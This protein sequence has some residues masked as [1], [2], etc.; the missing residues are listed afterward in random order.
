MCGPNP[1]AGDGGVLG[2]EDLAVVAPA[3]RLARAEGIDA[4]GP[5]SA[6]TAF[7][8]A[9]RE[10]TD[11][12]WRPTTTRVS[13]RSRRSTRP[14]GVYAVNWTLGLP[15][16]RTCVDH[17]TADDIAGKG[18]ADP[19]SLLAALRARRRARGLTADG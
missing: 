8:L 5:V 6:E 18:I 2:D 15:I 11:W 14:L 3:V 1:H 9:V 12:W 7:R 4:S 10:E 19:G 16:V 17:G 13:P